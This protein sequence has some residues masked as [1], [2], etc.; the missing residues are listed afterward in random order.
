[1]ATGIEN[2]QEGVM[3]PVDFPTGYDALAAIRPFEPL[4]LFRPHTVIYRVG[5]FREQFPGLISYAVRAN[6]EPM[7]LGELFANGVDWFSVNSLAEMELVWRYLPDA[8]MHYTAV[9]KP[10]EVVDIAYRRHR[11]RSFV[12]DHPREFNKIRAFGGPDA[13]VLVRLNVP[14]MTTHNEGDRFGCSV[15]GG[16]HLVREIVEA[17]YKV[18]LSV[19]VGSQVLDPRVYEEGFGRMREVLYRAPYGMDMISIGGGFPSPYESYSP[20]PLAEYMRTVKKGIKSLNLPRTC[21]VLAEPGRALV[22]DSMSIVARVDLRRGRFVYINDGLLGM[23]SSLNTA[24]K[25]S[26][27][28]VRLDEAP[29]PE[30]AEFSFSGPAGLINDLMPGPYALPADLKAGDYI[31]FGQM[32]AYS[33]TMR[34][35]FHSQ[36]S[37]RVVSVGDSSPYILFEDELPE[38]WR[39]RDN[40]NK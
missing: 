15:E 10:P 39:G 21:R 34:T 36:P 23:L 37:P 32:G 40:E 33:T 3:P 24:V 38:N 4:C 35:H 22:A 11:I 1:M 7:V 6:P 20:P 26:V 17:G 2:H 14:S 28:L 16:A 12:V 5:E 27:R 25:P 30:L 8:K 18:G 31:E 13:T 9:V 19:N 29:K